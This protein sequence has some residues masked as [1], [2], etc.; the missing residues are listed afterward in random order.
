M[1]RRAV[2]RPLRVQP[3][4]HGQ[5]EH[6]APERR[7]PAQ[8]QRDVETLPHGDP[9][10]PR[11]G[12]ADDLVLLP[13]HRHTQTSQIAAAELVLPIRVADDGP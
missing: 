12:H 2:Q 7:R 10:K 8:W 1:R 13:V 6:F 4:H 5:L 11:L 9:E 3:A